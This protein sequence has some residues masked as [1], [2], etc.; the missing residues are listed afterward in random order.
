[1]NETFKSKNKDK[2]ECS[3]KYKDY[4]NNN[5]TKKNTQIFQKSIFH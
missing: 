4:L 2:E 3:K 5:R 1:M